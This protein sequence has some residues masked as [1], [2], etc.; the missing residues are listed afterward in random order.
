MRYYARGESLIGDA[1]LLPT[2]S[3]LSGVQEAT[4]PLM[5][6]VL[7]VELDPNQVDPWL[8]SWRDTDRMHL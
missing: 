6:A 1:S 2:H 7:L 5:V 3:T 4:G 8:V